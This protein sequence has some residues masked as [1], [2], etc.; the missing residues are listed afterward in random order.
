[1]ER[2]VLVGQSPA[3]VAA[4]RSL[5]S[6][7]PEASVTVVSCDRQMP[8]DRGLFPSFLG[9]RVKE[10][11]LF[12]ETTDFY[13]AQR[14]DLVVDKDITRINFQRRRVFLSEKASLDYDVIFIAD[15][16]GIRL[17]DSKG[18][19][20]NGVFSLARLETVKSLL[21]YLPFTETAVVQVKGMSGLET[22][23]SLRSLGKE[24]IVV[25]SLP[26]LLEDRLEPSISGLLPVLLE[27][28]G[29]RL[30]ANNHI[31]DILG[32]NDVRAV[33]LKSG[34]VIACEMVIFDDALPDLRFLNE[35][36]LVSA[37]RF[38][39]TALMQTNVSGVYAMD[40]VAEMVSPRFLGDYTVCRCVAEEQAR[41]AVS[42][43][44]GETPVPADLFADRKEGLEKY[45]TQDELAQ[46][47]EALTG[48]H[49][50][51]EGGISGDG[52]PEPATG[53]LTA[54]D[55]PK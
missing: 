27:K 21:R 23:L 47:A 1:M 42:A 14:I 32:D 16:P 45:F 38:N 31:D 51:G 28:R 12:L 10:K 17:P 39:V 15:A 46:A 7:R 24:V 20:R 44:C 29:V 13:R 30:M 43:A 25:S 19:R 18:S 3:V 6:L 4:A 36:P 5:R 8:Y 35:G 37:E 34:K 49:P 33:R 55:L 54:G 41:I 22:A 52:L 53:E 50:A 2:A 40:A 9:R 48:A 26:V 11:D